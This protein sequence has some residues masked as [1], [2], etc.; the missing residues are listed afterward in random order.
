MGTALPEEVPSLVM[1]LLFKYNAKAEKAFKVDKED[2]LFAMERSPIRDVE[3]ERVLQTSLTD[4][5]SD[6]ELYMK[7]LDNSY[8][9]EGYSAFNAQDL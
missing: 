2:Y 5:V 8:A 4:R 3:I 9:Y 1:S 7:G 6:R